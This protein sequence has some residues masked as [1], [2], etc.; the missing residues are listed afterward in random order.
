MKDWEEKKNLPEFFFYV[1]TD[2]GMTFQL[3]LQH[4]TVTISAHLRTKKTTLT[5]R[6]VAPHLNGGLYFKSSLK[7]QMHILQKCQV[8]FEIVFLTVQFPS[9]DRVFMNF[10]VF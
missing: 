4:Q 10:R 5:C 2:T 8:V 6:H 3:I 9:L 1:H 7:L